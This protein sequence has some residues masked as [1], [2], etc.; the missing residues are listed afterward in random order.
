M[1]YP[2]FF[3]HLGEEEMDIPLDAVNNSTVIAATPR[4]PHAPLTYFTT[5]VREISSEQCLVVAPIISPEFIEA[6]QPLLEA[7]T[8]LELIY[9]KA[10]FEMVR[11]KYE[12]ELMSAFD[13]KKIALY[14]Y[15]EELSFGLVIFDEQ[16]F[17]HAYETSGQ[18]SACLKS[19]DP[20][21]YEW[22]KDK[23]AEYRDSARQIKDPSELP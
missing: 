19:T 1:E 13:M 12:D 7:G 11:T 15:P 20:M 2:Q 16:V 18:F 14:I 22:A 6:S 9:D 5:A 23:Y 3:N 10:V 8:T 17:V 21:L 4:N